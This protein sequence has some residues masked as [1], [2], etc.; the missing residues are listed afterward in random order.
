MFLYFEINIFTGEYIRRVIKY[1]C[2][3]FNI[4]LDQIYTITTD[5]GT[6]MLKAVKLMSSE[7]GD[8]D[9]DMESVEENQ[10]KDNEDD[11]VYLET[12][13]NGEEEI[14]YTEL[15]SDFDVLEEI[16]TIDDNYNFPNNI[17]TGKNFRN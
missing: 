14:D 5:N 17:L 1:V 13:E 12:E 4:S 7:D 2:C 15:N 10:K 6:N 11:D 9:I 16:E 8:Y 3:S